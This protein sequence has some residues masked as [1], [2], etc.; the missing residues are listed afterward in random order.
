MKDIDIRK[1]L[2]KRILVLDGAMGTMI[3]R[4]KLT[5]EDFRGTRLFSHPLDLK[6]NNDLLSIVR[7]DIIKNIHNA[8]LEA[9]SDIIETNTF[10]ANKFSQADYQ[11]ESFV[12]EIN[13]ESAKIAKECA[14]AFTINNPE[15][16]RFV[17]GALGPT[18]KT[19]SLSPDVNDPGYRAVSFD[20]LVEAYFEQTRGL[21]EGGADIL[22][23]ETIFDTLNAKAAIFAIDK[24]SAQT[25]INLPVMISGTIVDQSGRTLS[26]QTT[27][28][29][30]ISIAHTKNLLSV[31][32]NCSLGPSQMRPF[33]E[34]LSSITHTFVSLYPNAGLPNEFGQYDE[35]PEAMAKVL[36]E[37]AK[38]GFFNI[39]GGC[40]GTTPDHIRAFSEVASKHK[41]KV[42]KQSDN[43]LRLSGLEPLEF[44][45]D[46][47]FVNVGERT[48]VTG[49]KKFARLIKSGNYEE[50]L[51]IAR[52]Q[53]EGGAQVLDINMDEGMIDSG[54]VMI[55]FLNLVGA[56]PDIARLPVMLDSSKW[57]V[58]EA[59][60]KC[61]Q[62][63]GIVN[64]I[65]MK[66][67]EDAFI[68][69]AKKVLSYGAAVIVMAFDEKGQ[70]DTFQRKIEI[71]AR[72]YKLLT[73][74]VGFP[75][76][77]IILD[78][79][80]FAIATGIEEHN[81]YA[82][83]FIEATRWIKQNLPYAKVSGGVSNVSFSFRGNDAVREAIHSV[84][85]F[86]AI[87][88]GMDMGIVNPGQLGIYEE[89]PKELLLRVEDVI[90][91]RRSDATERLV[92]FAESVKPREKSEVQELEW[93][94]AP[95][96]ERLK[97]ALVKGI[98]DFIEQDTEEARKKL[99][100]P[101]D[102]IEGPLMD[103][104]NIVGDLFGSGKMFLP[105]VVKSARVMKKSVAYLIP[106]I[107]EDKKAS[108]GSR[109]TGKVVLAT[110]KGDVHDIGKNIVGVVLGCNNY[111][112]IDLGVMVPA[113][114]ILKAAIEMK[115]DILGLSGLITPSLDEMVHVAKE[116]ERLG[117]KIPLLIGGATTSRIHTAVKIAPNY[118]G[119]VIHVLDASKSVTVSGD[120]LSRNT[121]DSF[122]AGIR[123][124]YDDLREDHKKRM[125]AKELIKIQ[126]AR[127]NRSLLDW[128]IEKIITPK[129]TGVRKI[130]NIDLNL[131]R[132]YIDWT[133]FFQT[134]ELKGKYPEILTNKTY[135]IE[136]KK[137]FDD[138]NR[139]I[140]M[141]IEEKLISANGVCGIFPANS[142]GDD[143]EVYT[144]PG[145][146]GLLAELH[147]IRQQQQKSGTAP[148]L[149]LSDFI[150][151]K[152]SGRNDYIGAFA[153]TAGIGVDEL[154]AR[155][156]AAHD[157]YNSIMIKSVADRFAEAFAEYLHE[158]VR[159]E[160][161]GYAEDE[162]LSSEELIREKYTG[163]RPAPG[164]PAQPD[165]T[166]KPIIFELLHVEE[167]TGITLT[168]NLAMHPAASVSGLYFASPHAKY[169]TTGKI[170]KDQVVDYAK[171]KG[172]SLKET[173]RWLRPTLGY[174][175]TEL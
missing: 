111:E 12:Y 48:N 169:F 133:P 124:E 55:K 153:V 172:L 174:D 134:W 150:A 120:L 105:Q 35:S 37:Y 85:L 103:G 100:A 3:Q 106:Y 127:R 114:K 60:L 160:I 31:G 139:L 94:S 165:H 26:G 23:V 19:A 46:L 132:D 104:M 69:H 50:A 90:L 99:K 57:S 32:L 112:V 148:N 65:S 44:R 117:L 142:A 79:N 163:I 86:H 158:L 97:H 82:V 7:P 144:S 68:E 116:M 159:K 170:G 15:K 40:C 49:S 113:D 101:L 154:A 47:N 136:A 166:E 171:R 137:V 30:Y 119:P 93:R 20:D 92:E 59:G 24:Y 143:I 4:Y 88:A 5:E 27:A 123:K 125:N 118:S 152:D 56:E 87:K 29:F 38:N 131:L 14:T 18:N 138:A 61:L 168:E 89:I 98:V 67:G 16:P 71:C 8:Y 140:D 91:N 41:P 73:E 175:D 39:V 121:G 167:N 17:A 76:Q 84:F 64:S 146:E 141:I 34:E 96:E 36:D 110:V 58:I 74:K 161:W 66:E 151:P 25:G 145:R 107:E 9:G 164:Y 43:L 81:N 130:T 13:Y 78:P 28:A 45:T 33:I 22:L 157:D 156:E 128:N 75:P 108:G 52:D 1:I 72:A 149:A 42:L 80:V 109:S 95:V 122:T 173:E 147:T 115:A 2:E 6:G 51:S 53:V 62:G 155:Y 54:A 21:V 77:D 129:F 135:G 70:A 11:L 102:V 83:D 10:S 63:K 162:N 126:D